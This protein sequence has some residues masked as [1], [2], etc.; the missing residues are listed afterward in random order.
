[1]QSPGV[2]AAYLSGL[3]Q[4]CAAVEH[5][6][7]SLHEEQ[8]LVEG[9]ILRLINFLFVAEDG[10]SSSS[11]SGSGQAAGQQQATGQ[12]A[13]P[14]TSLHE[15]AAASMQ[16]TSHMCQLAEQA[17]QVQQVPAAVCAEL[18]LPHCCNHLGCSNLAG[19]GE[20]GLVGGKGSMCSGCRIARWAW[21]NGQKLQPCE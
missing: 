19:D 20:A 13:S 18:L 16:M 3:Q 8:Q 11:S 10:G 12:S 17:Q 15:M 5:L 14:P 9:A 21:P 1:M 2:A 7:P 6:H 4:R